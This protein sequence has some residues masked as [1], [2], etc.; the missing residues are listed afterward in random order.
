MAKKIDPAQI[1]LSG[2]ETVIVIQNGKAVRA[3]AQDVA[4]KAPAAPAPAIPVKS[5]AGKTGDVTLSKSDVGLGNTDNTSD[6]NKPVSN[7]QQAA[8]DASKI[9]IQRFTGTTNANGIA[10]FTFSPA[11]NN[12]PDV[13]V[14]EDWTSGGQMI[15]GKVVPGTITKTG[16]QAQIMLSVGTLL[17][18]ASPFNKAGAGVVA[19]VKASGN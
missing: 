10:T 2:S 5:V 12:V 11:F 6:A 1:P 17:L 8:I 16:C 9:R 15:T 7:A 4:N 13:D 3:S 19:T 18:N 14:I